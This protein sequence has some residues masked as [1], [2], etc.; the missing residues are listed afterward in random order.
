MLE[1]ASSNL[2]NSLFFHQATSPLSNRRAIGVEFPAISTWY[3]GGNQQSVHAGTTSI[4]CKT[5]ICC[6]C[7]SSTR[8][9][10]LANLFASP[11]NARF[12]C[13]CTVNGVHQHP[14]IFPMDR[15]MVAKIQSERKQH[16]CDSRSPCRSGTGGGQRSRFPR[17]WREIQDLPWLD[18]QY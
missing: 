10:A 5:C 12:C 14:Q 18:Q 3:D 6:P 13:C 15:E 9:Q 17:A 2:N 16:V 4:A 7:R 8:L 11:D 1:A